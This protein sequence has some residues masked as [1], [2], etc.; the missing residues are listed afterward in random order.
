[1]RSRSHL[2]LEVRSGL[3]LHPGVA[4]ALKFLETPT[5]ELGALVRAE[6]S[7]NPLLECLD[8][9]DEDTPPD[10]ECADQRSDFEPRDEETALP[11]GVHEVLEIP[12]DTD[13]I[14]WP[15]LGEWLLSQ[16]GLERL[17]PNEAR[18]S[19]IVIGSL[20]D[21][22]YL[23]VSIEEMARTSGHPATL[24]AAALDRVRQLEPA[25]IGAFDLRD[26]LLLQLRARGREDSLAARLV[27]DH[28]PELAARRV[29]DLERKLAL[30]PRAL[31]RALAEIR[32][33]RPHPGR[34]VQTEEVR[35]IYADVIIERVDGDYVVLLN[36]RGQPR[37]RL[38]ESGEV[39][40]SD[41]AEVREFLADRRRA[42]RWLLAALDRRRD[43]LLRV[44][45]AIVREQRGFFEHGALEMKPMTL[46]TLAGPLGLH[47]STVARVCQG[48][49][50]ETPRGLLA[51]RFFFSS[52]LETNEGAPVSSRSVRER[53]RRFIQ[54]EQR[55]HPWSDE[56]LAETLTREGV[57]IARRT[58]AKYREELG[59]AR[60]S[61]RRRRTA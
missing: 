52:Q 18:A 56:A 31:A 55:D 51:L 57:R 40:R 42:A 58:V 10:A 46:A 28:F 38:L 60:A 11:R 16:L 32:A 35:Y 3:K 59:L 7:A 4:L 48:K 43:T 8:D 34:L 24:L 2:S 29:L 50:A 33:L 1:M 14:A 21:R 17:E 15:S 5:L 39:P 20:D 13:R 19:R 36:E 41:R 30:P 12:N 26:C 6:A 9:E 45:R 22:G 53:I 47:E 27:R 44:V 61:E 49:Y 37:L 23:G 25:G 54:N